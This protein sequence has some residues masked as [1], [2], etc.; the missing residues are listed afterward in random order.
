[1]VQAPPRRSRVEPSSAP[2]AWLVE[3]LSREVQRREARDPSERRTSC[4]SSIEDH[5]ERAQPGTEGVRAEDGR[6]YVGGWMITPKSDLRAVGSGVAPAAGPG[7]PAG[8]VEDRDLTDE[9]VS[10]PRMV[11]DTP[12]PPTGQASV[13]WVG[14]AADRPSIRP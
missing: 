2:I 12:N 4:A 5:R 8:V 10:R 3:Q 14:P 7:A 11:A 1:M 9:A 13:M 6:S